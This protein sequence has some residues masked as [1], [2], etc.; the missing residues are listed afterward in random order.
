MKASS[1]PVALL[2]CLATAACLLVPL[3]NAQADDPYRVETH[4]PRIGTRV[5]L[6]LKDIVSG[7]N[8]NDRYEQLPSKQQRMMPQQP[9]YGAR[10]GGQRFSL[11]EP[12]PVNSMP[13]PSQSSFHN[14]EDRESPYTSADAPPAPPKSREPRHTEAANAEESLPPAKPKKVAATPRP[15]VPSKTVAEE[16][17]AKS[18]PPKEPA[19]SDSKAKETQTASHTSETTKRSWQSFGG[20]SSKSKQ[21]STE[22]ASE[23]KTVASTPASS[24]SATLTGSKTTK[25]GRVKSPYAPFNELDVTGLPTGSLAMDPTTGKVFRVP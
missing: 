19:H 14:Q 10:Q 1:F 15:P 13:P 22:V 17:P 20:D 2:S 24:H 6:F 18:A 9:A 16:K 23:N 25:E 21:T 5:L 3:R 12:P 8:P 11:D 7:E 4:G